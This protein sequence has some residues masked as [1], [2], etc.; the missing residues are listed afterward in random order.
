[1]VGTSPAPSARRPGQ[2]IWRGVNPRPDYVPPN[3]TCLPLNVVNIRCSL[4]KSRPD[5]AGSLCFDA[6]T[7]GA[8][9]RTHTRAPLATAHPQRL[10]QEVRALECVSL[11]MCA[12]RGEGYE[13]ERCIVQTPTPA[14]SPGP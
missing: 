13:K 12:I 11:P 4:F 7:E 1:M 6:A 10:F 2:D 14:R 3:L 5:V 8:T 9:G